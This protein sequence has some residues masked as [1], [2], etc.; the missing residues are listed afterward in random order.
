M[1]LCVC[2]KLSHFAAPQARAHAV[3][4]G[5]DYGGVTTTGGKIDTLR[6]GDS[7]SFC[8][9]P[10]LMTKRNRFCSCNSETNQNDPVKYTIIKQSYIYIYYILHKRD[11]ETFHEGKGDDTNRKGHAKTSS[12]EL[13]TQPPTPFLTYFQMK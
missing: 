6:N 2:T 9:H 4:S 1:L 12:G 11:G 3:A 5:I 13:P 10:R 7:G 8:Y